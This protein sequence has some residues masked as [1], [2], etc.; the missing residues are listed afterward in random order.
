MKKTTTILA[1]VL[2]AII[3]SA[4]AYGTYTMF[5]SNSSPSPSPS[6][7]T[8][9]PETSPTATTTSTPQPEAVT[10]VDVTNTSVEVTLPVNRIVNIAPG[11]TEVLCALGGGDKI[12]GRDSYSTFP[13][14]ITS[15]PVVAE[16]SFSPNMEQILE[17]NPDLIIADQGLS[18]NDR[19]RFKDAGVPVIEEMLME[20]R[21]TTAVQNF[22]LVLG[23]T[24]KANEYINFTVSYENLIQERVA[25]LPTS[26]RPKV[27]FEWY[28]QWYTSGIGD[29][30]DLMI[31]AAGGQNIAPQNL[32]ASNP[33]LSPEYIAEQNPAVIVRMLT[34]LDGEDLTA[35]QN[36][37]NDLMTRTALS[38]TTAVENG[39]V[40]VIHNNLLVLRPAI[41]M[42]YLAKWFHP[43]LFTDIDPTAVHE[44][45][46]QKFFNVTLDGVYVYPPT[47][48]TTSPTP[49][50]SASSSP[51]PTA[52]ASST[53]TSTVSPTSTPTPTATPAPEPQNIT[54]SDGAGRNITL[55]VPV[56]RIISINSGLTEMLCALG[57]GDNIVGRDDS[58]TLP[59]Y[60]LNVTSVGSDSYT[61]NVEVI[62]QLQPDVVFADSMLTY[63]EVAMNQLTDAGIPV[64]IADP[65]DPAPTQH[66]NST[67]VDFSCNLMNQLASIVGNQEKANEYVTYVQYYNKLVQDRLANLTQ[68]QK[69]KVMLEWYAP[70]NTFV[71]PG[72]D[73]AGGI[74]IAENQTIYAP[75]LSPEFVVEQNPAVIIYM[76]SSPNHDVNDF[77]AARNEILNRPELS[78][79]DAVTKGQVYVCDWASRGGIRC[80]VGYLYWAKWC[81]PSL[82]ADIDPAQINQEVNQKFFGTSIQGVFAYP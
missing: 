1:I 43:D 41:G 27:Y 11:A 76:V 3:I 40:Y 36:L 55:T 69:P 48:A 34:Q 79:V 16:S 68:S 47:V 58:S 75:V 44:E 25:I 7:S 46:I 13:P 17:L 33:I 67:V 59:P 39:D 71:T 26:E 77:I 29:S 70:Y 64:F 5:N 62:L 80:I 2:I 63:N 22:G 81:Q 23:Q 37:R 51:T 12:V 56:K 45:M 38:S 10:I 4:S 30:W 32:N 19:Q 65:T 28:Q 15:V 50:T 31:S 61:P 20:P 53:P 14:S 57:V 6:A 52:S 66:S 42:L 73:Q 21:L 8:P 74:N 54:V 72:L 78:D 24:E 18:D 35:F 60:M 49:A 9:T 82:F